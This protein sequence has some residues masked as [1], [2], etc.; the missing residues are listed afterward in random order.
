MNIIYIDDKGEEHEFLI[1]DTKIAG[2]DFH[3]N[4]EDGKDV[5]FLL[6]SGKIITLY[7]G[8]VNDEPWEQMKTYY[9]RFV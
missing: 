2:I 6:A 1:D 3:S 7:L 4:G 9:E 8:F 5:K